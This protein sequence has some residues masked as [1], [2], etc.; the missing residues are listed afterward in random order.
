MK[1]ISVLFTLVLSV[2]CIQAQSVLY[3]D[4]ENTLNEATVAGPTLTVLG[5]EGEFRIDTLDKI[6]QST[7]MVY[8]FGVN[9]GFQFSNTEAD[10]FLGHSY[11]IEL[12]MKFDELDSWKRVVDWKNRKSDYGAYI[13]YGRLN[14]YPYQYSDEVPVAPGEY[15]YYVITRDSA[16]QE[17]LIYTDAEVKISFI[18]VY[19]DALLDEDQ[20]LN[21]FH[22]DLV[23]PNEASSGTVAMLKIYSYT[24]DS[25]SIQNNYNE[26]GSQV[27]SVPEVGKSAQVNVYPNPA[28]DKLW[29]DFSGFDKSEQVNI[30]LM[31]VCGQSVLTNRLTATGS[32]MVQLELPELSNGIYILKVESAKNVFS[33]KV[34]ISH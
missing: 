30:R 13:Y 15:T 29:L 6:N 5:E 33:T 25:T 17:L 20:V 21:F 12:Y 26:I 4:F 28:S 27:F 11:T 10:G 23:V 32:A 2:H 1:K 22:D 9:S 24:M 3:Y 7:K 14:F 31:N 34:L 8:Q 18:D 16:S 19:G